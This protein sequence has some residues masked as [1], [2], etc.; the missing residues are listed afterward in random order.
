MVETVQHGADDRRLGVARL[1]LLRGMVVAG[2]IAAGYLTVVSWERGGAPAGCG[3]ETGC[4][5]VFGSKWARLWGVPVSG[6]GGGVVCRDAGGAA[7]GAR[8]RGSCDSSSGMVDGTGR[9]DGAGGGGGVV[10][11]VAMD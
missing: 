1:W 8:G 3:A 4:G 5:L 2:L 11:G 9:S 7:A 10:R 6:G